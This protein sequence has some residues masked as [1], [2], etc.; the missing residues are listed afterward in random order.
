[1]A[2]RKNSAELYELLRS[3]HDENKQKGKGPE[4]DVANLGRDGDRGS[5]FVP[6]VG[7]ALWSWL[8]GARAGTPGES[9]MT[10]TDR[11]QKR[12]TDSTIRMVGRRAVN[13]SERQLAPRQAP[14]RRHA[15]DSDVEE[16]R[17]VPGGGV[18]KETEGSVAADGG[19]GFRSILIPWRNST[20][21]TR[22]ASSSGDAPSSSFLSMASRNP[23]EQ[24]VEEPVTA[25]AVPVSEGV[26]SQ[27]KA[28][29]DVQECRSEAEHD[30]EAPGVG[31]SVSAMEGRVVEDV[32]LTRRTA[33]A[34]AFRGS[35]GDGSSNGDGSDGDGRSRV[36]GG[37]G[38]VTAAGPAPY[39]G[40]EKPVDE[41][42][43][44]TSEVTPP[45]SSGDDGDREGNP[46]PTEKKTHKK[47]QA[48]TND[49][50][51]TDSLAKD[52]SPKKSSRKKARTKAKSAQSRKQAKGTSPL[53]S[54]G[55]VGTVSPFVA[56][57]GSSGSAS[58]VL[59]ETAAQP[60]SVSGQPRH[61]EPV[62]N[63]SWCRRAL[64]A[65][66]G[67]EISSLFRKPLEIR[68]G[69]LLVAF[70]VIG[71]CG[72]IV[73]LYLERATR[74][75]DRGHLLGSD[76]AI[77][78]QQGPGPSGFALDPSS[79]QG[80]VASETSLQGDSSLVSGDDPDGFGPLEVIAPNPQPSPAIRHVQGPNPDRTAAT[81][82]AESPGDESDGFVEPDR[83]GL[84]DKHFVQVAA[85]MRLAE[86]RNAARHL[87]ATHG[88]KNILRNP[89][90]RGSARQDELYSLLLG[91]YAEK[92]AA[93]QEVE[94]IRAFYRKKPLSR[95][96]NWRKLRLP[97]TFGKDAYARSPTVVAEMMAYQ[98]GG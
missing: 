14:Q 89:H 82:A 12:G 85:R 52:E 49:A 94:S 26:S 29:A 38:T 77:Q 7:V 3:M 84:R 80:M 46:P 60:L 45:R 47:K 87:T 44:S 86:F 62:A 50:A 76:P 17:Q 81:E 23:V 4:Q 53:T 72:A 55:A 83:A 8:K 51:S 30:E 61:N 66:F 21:S 6:S 64:E 16:P 41:Q 78:H 43:P 48:E 25:S 42:E 54:S 10:A 63:S 1:M 57:S 73:V 65:V 20:S 2:R 91:P 92:G 67:D 33:V 22:S 15:R 59:T 40:L 39:D 27:R 5:S 70:V 58:S 69:T 56:G 32:R 95:F 97:V 79:Q 18:G 11:A 24:G 96:P 71:I 93:D 68:F 13:E 28:S 35:D 19:L 9:G 34:P 74:S 75:N 98:S 88:Y 31:P 37:E 36:G 90:S